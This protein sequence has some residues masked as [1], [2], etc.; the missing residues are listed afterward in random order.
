MDVTQA[1][2]KIR[3][4]RGTVV[5]LTIERTLNGEAEILEFDVKR[6]KIALE[7]I[8]EARVLPQGI[9]YI[10]IH[11]FKKNTAD[12]LANEIKELRDEGMRSL[13][14]DLRWNPG[15]LL[16]AAKDV[17]ELFLPRNTL[18]TYTKGR[19]TDEV[20][21]DKMEF[22]TERAPILPENFPMVVLVNELSASA[23]EIVTGALQFY[24]RA[25]VVGTKTYGK[26]SVQTLIALQRPPGSAL[27][28]TTAL[29][30]T[31]ARVT[32]DRM[33]IKPDVEAPMERKEWAALWTQMYSYYEGEDPS[34][35]N[36]QNHGAVTGNEVTEDTV[37]DVQLKRAVEI[38]LEDPVFDN[39]IAKYH[40]DPHETQVAAAENGGP[41]PDETAQEDTYEVE[42][43]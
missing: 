5:H 25:I 24:S 33:G 43:E 14:L 20:P 7:S 6:D 42:A 36:Q 29:Y 30:Y 13:V 4:R 32:I 26:G 31:P 23:S 15:G 16:N 2:E 17:S 3:G 9:G 27:R 37:E 8:S 21:A 1:A 11:D 34:L 19:E 28:L 35:K 22:Y 12:D 41:A 18:V 40:K 10:R 38:L 39:L